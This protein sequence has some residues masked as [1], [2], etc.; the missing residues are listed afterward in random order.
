MVYS[1]QLAPSSGGEWVWSQ[2]RSRGQRRSFAA[3]QCHPRRVGP[4]EHQ[5]TGLAG[6]TG[7]DEWNIPAELAQKM[8]KEPAQNRTT[9]KSF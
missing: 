8:L 6:P 1:I 2:E 5:P 9:Q 4:P 3:P 7:F